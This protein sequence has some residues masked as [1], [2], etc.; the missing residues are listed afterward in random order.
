VGRLAGGFQSFDGF[1]SLLLD[2]SGCQLPFA[3]ASGGAG[4]GHCLCRKEGR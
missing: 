4:A 2:V 1:L 3:H